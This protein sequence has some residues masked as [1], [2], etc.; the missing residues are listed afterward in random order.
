MWIKSGRQILPP[1]QQSKFNNSRVQKDFSENSGKSI[2]E[3]WRKTFLPFWLCW[4]PC[5]FWLDLHPMKLKSKVALLFSKPQR[6]LPSSLFPV[7]W[8]SAL[9]TFR[10]ATRKLWTSTGSSW[11]KTRKLQ[12]PQKESKLC[13]QRAKDCVDK[14]K[15]QSSIRKLLANFFHLPTSPRF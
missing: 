2:L 8:V 14:D 6:R 12:A 13:F 15:I 9:W 10:I 4:F 11:L 5:W 3:G 7:T 1:S